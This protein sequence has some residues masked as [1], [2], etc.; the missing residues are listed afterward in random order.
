ML[1]TRSH[2]KSTSFLAAI[3]ASLAVG[4]GPNPLPQITPSRARHRGKSKGGQM[5]A[6]PW[7]QRRFRAFRG[8]ACPEW[9]HG[10]PLYPLPR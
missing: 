1:F 6:L 4:S 3:L 7:R 2:M 5:D 9:Q 10:E 8:I